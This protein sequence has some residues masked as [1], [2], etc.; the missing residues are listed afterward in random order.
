MRHFRKDPSWW[1][2]MLNRFFLFLPKIQNRQ[3][4]TEQKTTKLTD[5]GKKK[6]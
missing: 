6:R 2:S 5:S 4:A 1:L 3:H